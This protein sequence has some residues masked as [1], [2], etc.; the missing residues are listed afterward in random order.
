MA[1]I[2]QDHPTLR[3]VSPR[4]WIRKTGYPELEF[5]QSLQ[6]FSRQ[7]EES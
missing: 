7:R 3:Y 4:T 5:Y 6:F 2:T 1:M